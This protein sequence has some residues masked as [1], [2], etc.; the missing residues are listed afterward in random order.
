M[1]T[2]TAGFAIGAAAATAGGVA[3]TFDASATGAFDSSLIGTAAGVIGDFVG[4]AI[5]NMGPGGLPPMMQ[6]PPGFDKQK[7]PGMEENKNQ[8]GPP[9]QEG[10]MMDERAA[11]MA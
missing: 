2:A 8:G 4:G 9:G 10:G 11:V 5:A 6:L 7:F 3:G 1:D